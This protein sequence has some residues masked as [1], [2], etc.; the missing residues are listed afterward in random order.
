MF[1][2]KADD[3]T[4]L[5]ISLPTFLFFV[6]FL[7]FI[8]FLSILVFMVSFLYL[9]IV[10]FYANRQ[11]SLV[12]CIYLSL[13]FRFSFPFWPPLNS[14]LIFWS[15]LTCLLRILPSSLSCLFSSSFFTL[16]LFL[17]ITFTL[18]FS[19]ILLFFLCCCLN[20]KKKARKWEWK[21]QPVS[22]C[23]LFVWSTSFKGLH[24]Q[25]FLP[26]WISKNILI[27]NN[28]KF[29]AVATNEQQTLTFILRPLL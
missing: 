4:I 27:D 24:R 5:L 13:N 16:F 22:H 6:V 21:T 12:F 3:K 15:L 23:Y 17:V 29:N 20:F 10:R 18:S 25:N 19:S 9:L 8:C 14:P 26:S 2:V 28:G 7:T 1:C 11:H